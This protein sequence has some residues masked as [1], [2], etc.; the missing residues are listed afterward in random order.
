MLCREYIPFLSTKN[1]QPKSD[2]LSAPRCRQALSADG[3]CPRRL[4]G[5]FGGITT[6]SKVRVP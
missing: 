1:Q 5:E 4:P 2:V 6:K 3:C